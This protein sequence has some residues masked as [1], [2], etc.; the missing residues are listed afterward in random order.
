MWTRW[1]KR[2]VGLWGTS[3]Q[4]CGCAIF[5]DFPADLPAEFFGLDDSREPRNMSRGDGLRYDDRHARNDGGGMPTVGDGG[6]RRG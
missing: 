6:V 5:R 2:I 4:M 3:C 1:P